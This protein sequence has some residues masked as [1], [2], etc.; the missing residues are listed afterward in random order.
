MPART[1]SDAVKALLTPGLN[2][3]TKRQ[4]SLTPFIDT[5]ALQ[6]DGMVELAAVDGISY[7]AERL[8]MIERWLA[9]HGYK[10]SDKDQVS[11]STRGASAS[12][13]GSTDMGLDATLYGQQ[14]KRLDPYG[15]L[16]LAIEGAGGQPTAGGQW[17]GKNPDQQNEYGA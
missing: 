12:F 11:R 16:S 1:N 3:D 6:V 2:Y 15:Y 9:A 8:E 5:A 10:L 14:A 7:T 4:P 13:A 17:L